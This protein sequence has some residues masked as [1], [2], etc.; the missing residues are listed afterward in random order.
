VTETGLACPALPSRLE[1]A[2][3][4]AVIAELALKR[5]L[6]AFLGGLFGGIGSV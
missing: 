5:R 1:A 6:A 3:R 2:F 4:F